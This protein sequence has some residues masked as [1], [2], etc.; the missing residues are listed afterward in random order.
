MR[1]KKEDP[2]E[3]LKQ[4]IYDVFENSKK[5]MFYGYENEFQTIDD[6]RRGIEIYIKRYNEERINVKRKGLS[7]L[8]YRHQS[9]I[10]IYY[11]IN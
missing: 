9:F 11:L 1:L 3:H 6:L 8:E 10:Q 4:L 7:P 2:N 5:E